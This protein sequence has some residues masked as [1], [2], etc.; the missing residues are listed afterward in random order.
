MFIFKNGAISDHEKLFLTT[1][2]SFPVV[3]YCRRGTGGIEKWKL[4][5]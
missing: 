3:K 2:D 4:S 5:N 1:R